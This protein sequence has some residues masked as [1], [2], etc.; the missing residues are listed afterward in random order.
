MKSALPSDPA[1]RDWLGF[2]LCP[3]QKDGIRLDYLPGT[4]A[5]RWRAGKELKCLVHSSVPLF[6]PQ[7]CKIKSCWWVSLCFLM[8]VKVQFN[9]SQQEKRSRNVL[10]SQALSLVVELHRSLDQVSQQRWKSNPW[11]FEHSFVFPAKVLLASFRNIHLISLIFLKSEMN[12]VPIENW[13]QSGN[14]IKC[15]KF[16]FS[17][18]PVIWIFF[19]LCLPH[20]LLL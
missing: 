18:S 13:W 14:V 16:S 4:G 12:H 8:S 11:H 5:S 2:V 1:G 9:W 15:V 17:I 6:H 19:P 7:K 3:A 20:S 10:S